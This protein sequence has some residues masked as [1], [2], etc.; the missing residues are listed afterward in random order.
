MTAVERCY[1]LLPALPT[2]L[3]VKLAQVT[4]KAKNEKIGIAKI[5]RLPFQI[6]GCEVVDFAERSLTE[7]PA[8]EG[9][10]SS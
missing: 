5:K 3:V 10:K 6:F 8:I 7:S 2:H 9:E 1:F 4:G